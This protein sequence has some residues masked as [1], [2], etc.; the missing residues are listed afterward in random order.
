[1][2][3]SAALSLDSC[4]PDTLAVLTVAPSPDLGRRLSQSR[5]ETLLRRATGKQRL[6]DRRHDPGRIDI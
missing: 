6:H 1:L 3:T 5:I 4:D 2:T